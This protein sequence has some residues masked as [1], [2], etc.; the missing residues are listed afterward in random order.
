MP[1]PQN[2]DSF[3]TLVEIIALLR[4]P[5][6]CPWDRKQTH[7]SLRKNLLEEA[8]EVL[9]AMDEA[10]ME[11]ISEEFGDL[12][13]QIVLHSQIAADSGEFTI[14]EVI[15]KINEKLIHR[16]PHVFGDVS[17]KNAEEVTVNWEALKK[18][19]RKKE[20]SMLD[21]VPADM[22]ALAYSQAIQGRVARVGFDW[23][24]D[25]GVLEKMAEEIGEFKVADSQQQKEEEFGDILF[26]LANFARRQG[27]DLESALR[28]SNRRFYK[29]F[30]TMEQ[31]CRN[32]GLDL[33]KLSFDEQNELWEEAKQMLGE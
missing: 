25:S 27:I 32:R 28:Q 8:Y 20:A 10:D 4:S 33:S 5:D 17:V 15:R 2:L 24:E 29:R 11:K 30:S 6:G 31:F 9:E 1:L 13:L 12:L 3:T 14:S 23:Q 16:H 19:E 7:E 26:T 21:G 18:Q 22:P